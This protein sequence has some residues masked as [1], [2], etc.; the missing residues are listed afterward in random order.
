MSLEF[1][2][3]ITAGMTIET[4]Q[5]LLTPLMAGCQRYAKG[6]KYSSVQGFQLVKMLITHSVAEKCKEML[7][8]RFTQLAHVNG[9]WNFTPD[10]RMSSQRHA[11]SI[12]VCFF[13][14]LRNTQ[15]FFV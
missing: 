2:R 15:V 10:H 5:C 6:A 9:M 8:A 3:I 1:V 12:Y 11:Y 13:L 4:P 7:V 14:L